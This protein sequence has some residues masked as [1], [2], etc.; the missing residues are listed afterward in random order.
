MRGN[1]KAHATS[2]VISHSISRATSHATSTATNPVR[3]QS[4][5]HSIGDVFNIMQP[6]SLLVAFAQCTRC[7]S[8]SRGQLF[9]FA[10]IGKR[11]RVLQTGRQS[12]QPLRFRGSQIIVM[13]NYKCVAFKTFGCTLEIVAREAYFFPPFILSLHS[14]EMQKI[15]KYM[16]R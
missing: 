6:P 16:L 3:S 7:G 5:L 10:S 9:K 8:G 13:H 15:R 14:G 11:T 1:H 12:C 2:C 4:S